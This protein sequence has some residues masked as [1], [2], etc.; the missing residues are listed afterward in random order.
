MKN[1]KDNEQLEQERKGI[2]LKTLDE[3]ARHI[4]EIYQIL[5]E[6]KEIREETI[7]T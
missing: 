5:K 4:K 3:T 1:W 6:D 7:I 2:S